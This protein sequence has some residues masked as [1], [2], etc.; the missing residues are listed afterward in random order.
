[1]M[2]ILG[3]V[4]L[5]LILSGLFSGLETGHY[6]LNRVRLKKRVEEHQPHAIRLYDGVRDPQTFLFTILI[7]N[8]IC[9]YLAS[10]LMTGFYANEVG[11]G[12]E[13]QLLLG[14]IPWS[15]EAAATFTLMLPFFLFGEAGPKNFFRLHP[16][17]MYRLSWPL[18][19]LTW[20]FLPLSRPLKWLAALLSGPQINLGEEFE[21]LNINR[22]RTFLHEGVE[23]GVITH[24]QNRIIDNFMNAGSIPITQLMLPLPQLATLPDTATVDECKAFFRLH[25]HRRIPVYHHREDHLVGILSFFALISAELEGNSQIKNY[26]TPLNRISDKLTLEETFHYLQS[27]H[28]AAV[29]VTDESGQTLGLIRLTDIIRRLTSVQ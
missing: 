25:N 6:C 19:I 26:I 18:C 20:L 5:T 22:L 24:T 11:M 17:V 7:G 12:T 29:A 21:Q 9:A 4:L 14:F 10:S 16:S 1:M 23:E 13:T 2:L 27:R 3:G 28:L 15:S 8:N